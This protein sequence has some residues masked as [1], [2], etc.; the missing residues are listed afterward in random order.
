M[1]LMISRIQI[2]ERVYIYIDIVQIKG[3][4]VETESEATR[5]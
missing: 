1:P 2:L 5:N 3:W 4:D